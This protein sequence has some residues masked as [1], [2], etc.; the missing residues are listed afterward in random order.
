M[1]ALIMAS[2]KNKPAVTVF[3]LTIVLLGSLSLYSIPI[4]IL[5]VFKSPAVMVLTFYGGMPPKNVERDITNPLERWTGMAPGIK[6]QES[7]STLGASVIFNYF[8]GDA[9]PGQALTTVSS[10]AQSE[11]TNLPPGT[12]P[13]VVLPFDP[14]ATTPVCLIAL[15]STEYGETTLYDVGRYE[16]RN[17]IMAV[18]GAVS[19]VVFGGKIRAIQIYLDREQMQARRLAPLDVMEA[20]ADS[21]VFLPAGELIVGDKDYFVDSNAMFPD[22]ESMGEIPLRTEHGNRAFVRDVGTPTDDALIQTTIVRVGGRKQVYVPVMRQQGASTLK[23]VEQLKQKLPQMQGRLTRP[24]IKLEMIMDQSIYVR[25]SI[26]SLAIEACLGAALCSLVILIFL[27]QPRMTAIAIMTIPIAALSA[28]ALL[29]VTGQTI[30]VMTLS[31]LAMAIGPMVDSAIICLENTDRVREEGASLEESALEGASQ[32]ALP[33][34]VSSLSTLLVLTPLAVMPGASSFLFRPM[35]MAV[36]FAMA[37]A[38]ILSRTLIPACAASWLPEAEGETHEKEARK[39]QQEEQRGLISRGF[40][41]WQQLIEA[42]IDRY[43]KVLDVVL[44]HRW[45]TVI[46]AFGL[47]FIVVGALAMPLRREF[48]P[49]V[50]GGAF[51]MYVRAPSGTRLEVTNDRIAEVE[52]FV[53]QTIP[54]KDLHL[55]VSQIG[56]TPD[57]SAAYTKNTGKMDA[58]M[59]IQLSEEREGTAQE[60]VRQ[61]RNAFARERRFADLQFAFNSGGLIRGALNE[62]KVTPINIRVTGKKHKKAHEIADLIRRKASAIDGVVDARVMQRQDYPQFVID[63]DRAKAADLGLTQE[64][65][66]KSVIAAL[67]SSILFNKNIFWID[68]VSGNQYFVGVQYPLAEIESLETLLDV[69]VTG[70]SQWRL[71]RR[72]AA[73]RTPQLTTPTYR[74]R[75]QIPAPVPLSNLVDI[76]RNTVGTE[77]SHIDIR[78]TIDISLNVVERDLGHV[79]DDVQEALNAFGERQGAASAESESLGTT[80]QAYDPSAE[81]KQLLEGTDIVLSGEYSRM[82]QTFRN[83]A[84]GLVLAVILIYFMMVALEKSFRAPICVLLAVPLILIGVMPML[85]LTKTSINV[86]SLL[87]I[88]FSVG[89]SVANTVLLT[90]VA[91]D[92]RKQEQLSALEA[93]RKAASIRARP[94]TMTALAAFFAMIPTALA[95]E[96]GSEANAP[97]GRAILGGLLAAEPATLLVVPALYTL[98]MSGRADSGG[99]SSDTEDAEDRQEKEGAADAGE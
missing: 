84:I 27:G 60:Y 90:D 41:R 2:L 51:V 80:W 13:P 79:A 5:P 34:L 33:E 22:A 91:Q 37:T 48:F 16:V 62:G 57:W 43:V 40:A 7:R 50:D 29:Y 70:V 38:Y 52:D 20:V 45:L 21:N 39:Q 61:L 58:T 32:V 69:P 8:Y 93:I 42:A 96:K 63:V 68:S 18:Q 15:N 44:A 12:L 31:G 53:R 87:G 94:V 46:C 64:D 10:L 28:A 82:K 54:K 19:P 97:L 86:Q 66:M 73:S 71:G 25:Q 99:G 77:I 11:V 36:G 78:P 74:G 75:Q 56:I 88:I 83:L 47:L 14:T 35:T 17:Q 85:Y 1:R 23:V 59:R 49:I 3:A 9:D 81:G 72:A 55:I 26:K 89:I 65:V 98:L 24:G 92:F 95:L 30:N 67:N 76:R 6:R 4:D